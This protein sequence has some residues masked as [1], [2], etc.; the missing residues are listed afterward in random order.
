MFFGEIFDWK[1]ATSLYFNS[2]KKSRSEEVQFD[3][4]DG[5]TLI[6]I[7]NNFEKHTQ[8]LIEA[9]QTDFDEFF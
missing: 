9:N 5:R 2:D 3:E 8:K 1:D 6:T 4:R 7:D